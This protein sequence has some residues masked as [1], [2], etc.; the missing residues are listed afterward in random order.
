MTITPPDYGPTNGAAYAGRPGGIPVEL[1]RKIRRIEIRVRRLLNTLFLGEYHS[2]FKG[3]GMEFSEVREY[4][5]GD[6]IRAIDWNVT[7][8]MNAP[9]VKQFVEERELSVILVVDVS[10][11][12]GYGS[13]GQSK[14]EVATELAAL[15]AFSAIRNN[16][17]VGLVAFTDQ[18]EKFV[19]PRKGREHVL[20]VIRELLYLAPRGRGTNIAGALSY[21]SRVIKR[22]SVVFL[23]SDFM[24][25]EYG[26]TL[27]VTGRRHDVIAVTVTDPLE[28]ALP[29]A[30]LV[31]LADA[32]TGDTILVDAGDPAVRAEYRHLALEALGQ[33]DRLL[34]S[35]K[36]DRVD[37]RTD[38]SYVEPLAQY[39]RRRARRD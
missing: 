37:V 35:V 33:R 27:R 3:Q 6:D 17:K 10:A 7:A 9:F 2:V 30:G 36:V 18:V 38:R 13:T 16:D 28:H 39:F 32:E 15:L 5:P 8:R 34:Q 19:P 1:L 14:L 12:G 4:V 11:S 23:I 21:V 29:P 25:A 26:S 22:K 20:R 31:T 24:A